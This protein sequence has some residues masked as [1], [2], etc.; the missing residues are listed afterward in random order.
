MVNVKDIVTI[1]CY[2]KEEKMERG[3]AIDFYKQCVMCSEGS[4]KNRYVNIL[5]QLLD[6]NTYC[7]D[8]E[9]YA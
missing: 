2:S 6:G 7:S 4:E 3:D 5:M 9:E 8:E 1:K